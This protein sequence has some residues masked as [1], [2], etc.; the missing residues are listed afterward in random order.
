M[1]AY[2]RFLKYVSVWTTSDETSETVPST[3]RQFDLGRLLVQELKDIGVEKVE[4]NDMCYLYAEIPATP[5]YEDQPAIGLIAHMDTV[6]DFSGKDIHPQ[7]IENYN[8]EDVKLGDSGRVLSVKEF[9]HLKNMKGRTL[10][11]T[12]GD[13]A[14]GGGRQG[15][16]S[17]DHHSGRGDPEGEYPPWKDL[18]RFYP[19]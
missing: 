14:S 18:Y 13:H 11:T 7:I 10:I 19:G 1:K 3:E 9:P 6:M 4:L 15:G 12:D 8:G 2:E 17:G 16:Y 5:G